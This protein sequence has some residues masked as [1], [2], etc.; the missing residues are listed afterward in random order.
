MRDLRHIAAGELVWRDGLDDRPVFF[1]REILPAAVEVVNFRA[2]LFVTLSTCLVLGRYAN[3]DA[4]ALPLGQLIKGLPG[5]SA[6]Q[7]H[8]H[9]LPTLDV[10][11]K[12]E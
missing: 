3:P 8:H 4:D 12:N 7:S 1:K 11:M 9:L 2:D 5:R 6:Y 10:T